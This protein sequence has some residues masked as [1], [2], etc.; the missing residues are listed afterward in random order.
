MASVALILAMHISIV[1]LFTPQ[2]GIGE[3][4]QQTIVQSVQWQSVV[5]DRQAQV[6]DGGLVRWIWN[7]K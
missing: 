3:D 2:V 7:W 5:Q 4:G 1:P 6:P